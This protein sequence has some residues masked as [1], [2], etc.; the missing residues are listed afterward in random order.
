M[1]EDLELTAYMRIFLSERILPSLTQAPPNV[2]QASLAGSEA[3]LQSGPHPSMRLP[4]ES[5][6]NLEVELNSLNEQIRRYP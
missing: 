5:F 6:L 4:S 3:M 1:A 2:S